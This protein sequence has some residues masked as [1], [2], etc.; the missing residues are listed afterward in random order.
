[1]LKA[2]AIFS[3]SALLFSSVPCYAASSETVTVRASQGQA[4]HVVVHNDTLDMDITSNPYVYLDNVDSSD[5]KKSATITVSL[6]DVNGSTD[7]DED[8]E[9]QFTP[10][11]TTGSLVITDI[12]PAGVK[13][14]KTLRL[15]AY[16]TEN[17]EDTPL[18]PGT[19]PIEF[20]NSAQTTGI[21][22]RCTVLSPAS[23]MNIFWNGSTE[24]LPL[25]DYCPSNS[26]GKTAV[27]GHSY[28]LSATLIPKNATDKAAWKVSD[29]I[30]TGASGTYI[31]NT[32]KAEIT[33]DGRFTALEEG[34]VTII[35]YFPSTPSSPR[36]NTYGEK[37]LIV[38]GEETTSI[39]KTVP[40]YI[41]VSI[42]KE[43]PAADIVFTNA[44]DTLEEGDVMNIKAEV[45]PTYT[46]DG[47]G[48]VTDE[49]KW[50]SSNSKVISVTQ[51]G[52]I[53]AVGAGTAVV[54]LY[55]EDRS[56]CAEQTIKVFK[57]ATDM[58]LSS[59]TLS[60]RVGVPVELTAQ[61][62]PSN[63]KDEIVWKSS[64][65]GVAEVTPISDAIT[66]QQTALVK[67][68]SE[69]SATITATAVNS[70]ITRTATV[71]VGARIESDGIS[72]SFKDPA[73][74]ENTI[75]ENGT[76]TLYTDQDLEI[77]STLT[78]LD[79]STP[80][81]YT[82]WTITNNEN[83]YVTEKAV[84][85]DTVTLHGSY[86]GS[87]LV[88]AHAS[89]DPSVRRTF[90]IQVQKSCD[91]LRAYD[92]N[93]VMIT[94]AKSIL[95]GSIMTMQTEM[96]MKD[97]DAATTDHVVLIQSSDPSVATVDRN[98]SV[99][100]LKRGLTRIDIISASGKKKSFNLTVFTPTSIRV[101]GTT[102]DGEEALPY[103]ELEVK[104]DNPTTKQFV[105]E[106]KGTD[107]KL[108]SYPDIEW[109]SSNESVASASPS[110]VFTIN[111]FGQTTV[112]AKCGTVSCQFN[113]YVY[114]QISAATVSEPPSETYSPAKTVYEPHPTLTFFS[115]PL[116][117]GE[118][119]TVEYKNNTSIGT[120]T[121]TYTGIGYLRNTKNV[122]FVISKK[123]LSD[124]DVSYSL[125]SKIQSTG[126]ALTP[127]PEITYSGVKLTEKTDFTC[128]YTDNVNIGTAKLTVR[129]I[130]NYEGSVDLQFEIYC[131]HKETTEPVIKQEA[132][133]EH[134]GL[135]T[136]ECK[137][138]GMT[139]SEEIPQLEHTFTDKVFAPTA[140]DRGYT[141]HTC[142][143]CGYSYKD[144][145]VD[146][147][148]GTSI[149]DCTATIAGDTFAYT[150][151]P[152]TPAV[153][154]R[155]NGSVL[156]ENADYTV[157]YLS[158]TDIGTGY[159]I[160]VGMG[161]YTGT[162][163]ISFTITNN[164]AVDGSDRDDK[165]AEL[166]MTDPDEENDPDRISI[167]QKEVITIDP[168]T[169]SPEIVPIEPKPVVSLKGNA[170]I[171]NVDYTLG[172]ANN[173]DVGTA[174]I[175]MKGIG[176]YK[177]IAQFRFEILPKPLTSE[178]ITVRAID[179]Q[180]CTGKELTPP[181]IVLCGG[182]ILASNRDYKVTYSDN[183]KPG[184]AT[185]TIE[186]IGNYSDSL[187][188]NFEITCIHEYEEEVVPATHESR[189]YT[190]HTC[191]ICGATFKDNYTDQLI[192]SDLSE[193]DIS[194]PYEF[195]PYTGSPVTPQPQVKY[196]G[197]PLEEGTDFTVSYANNTNV[198][199]ADVTIRGTGN[200]TGMKKLSFQI[201]SGMLGDVNSDGIITADDALMALRNT[202]GLLHLNETQK[203]LADVTGDGEVTT[204]DSLAILRYTVGFFDP[205]MPI[206][207]S[208][209]GIMVTKEQ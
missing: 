146:T 129:G 4:D 90:Y 153:T 195:A 10:T 116:I 7:V 161:N 66:N 43:N 165:V 98:G 16:T 3:A 169:Y 147:I 77:R 64:N 69:G 134:P 97:E 107:G 157:M 114:C 209:K 186:G 56:V 101:L 194:L 158:N 201:I 40:K 35:G 78:S 152:I 208:P 74:V 17:G 72:L 58:T 163:K 119:Y 1:M 70:G 181:T 124:S 168:V 110:G 162:G 83:E 188:V 102:E 59:D 182:A 65:I 38:D 47:Y 54:A 203:M 18:N 19:V 50:E 155:H 175:V 207:S 57:K 34:T 177:G 33:T 173:T 13:S 26:T 156:T 204:E 39:V 125:P 132:T 48:D 140:N 166:V 9:L 99:R 76:I 63:A 135:I 106:V 75:T 118:D 174:T 80:D 109:T 196:K 111:G 200:F 49:M 85:N 184:I 178:E 127:V 104:R 154:L 22:V 138:C 159:V 28:T 187:S 71:T 192:I 94:T 151:E 164:P 87:V 14:S 130:G 131:N 20:I 144:N 92:Q 46:G 67:G 148:E 133:C 205:S 42:I 197:R 91:E 23:D 82:E 84:T 15:D 103:M 172:Y 122:S 68:V 44:P 30:Y 206:G 79:G 160:I 95:I 8:E 128:S 52:L 25:N 41:H 193:C 199:I 190:L 180:L 96:Y 198:G 55:S 86:E 120:A 113:F 167:T 121:I 21:T 123:K 29:G 145:Y 142:S 149:L 100:G 115:V 108:V 93:D 36:M 27:V 136:R 11:D 81:D 176:K 170:L 143:V 61:L 179:T 139:I 37:S 5:G 53:K 89:S 12:T 183:I 73:G 202:V 191:T 60:T 150:G 112:T 62:S 185:A 31:T 6:A 105:A 117:E 24:P 45:T 141:L 171:E 189:G 137:E 51:T 88:T 32:T 126:K 2:F